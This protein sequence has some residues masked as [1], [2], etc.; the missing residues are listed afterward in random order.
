VDYVT[1]NRGIDERVIPGVRSAAVEGLLVETDQYGRFHL[2]GVDGGRW[3]RGRNFILKVDPATLPPGS[4][5]TTENPRL[6]RVTPGLPVRFDFGVKLPSGLV[7]GGSQ[8]VELELGE[9]VCDPGSAA[10]CGDCLPVVDEMAAQVRAHGAGEVLIAA[11]GEQEA[12][13]YERAKAVREAL[14]ARLDPALAQATT[15]SLRT[16]LADPGSTLLSLRASPV[17]GTVL[18]DTGKATIRSEFTPVIESIAA[19]LEA[20]GGG[21]VGI[22][23]HADRRGPDAGNAALGLRR[24]KAVY[25]A[26]AARLGAEARRRLRVEINDDPTAPAGATSR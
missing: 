14:L 23:G 12:L 9:V 22:T 25:E 8:A 5:F 21:V 20:L 11:S 7:E 4:G 26:I 2:T 18:F 6:R 1:W 16:D 13:A 10:L 15:V 19:D 17:L 24:A 3:E